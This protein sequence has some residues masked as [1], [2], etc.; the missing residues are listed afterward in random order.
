MRRLR[1]LSCLVP[2]VALVGLQAEPFRGEVVAVLPETQQVTVRAIDA[3]STADAETV[4]VGPGD[5][6][7]AHAGWKV[8]GDLV[9]MG[10]LRRLQTVWPDDSQAWAMVEQLGSRLIVDTRTRGSRAFRN[11]GEYMPAVALFD[12][13]GQLFLSESLKGNYVV[14]NFIFTR[15]PVPT[16]CPLSTQKMIDLQAAAQAAGIT[17]VELVS[18]TLDPDYDTP[19]IFTAYAQS[20]SI[21][22]THFHFLGGP[23]EILHALRDQMG[24]LAEPDPKQIVKH[25]LSTALI[26][27]TGKII[28]RV[29]GSQWS[30]ADFLA[31]IE[32]HRTA[33]R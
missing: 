30:A 23:K 18:C 1:F 2:L 8:R 27:P 7:L 14:M 10:A 3:A 19:G 13:D 5:L 25:T 22:T 4:F 12:Q 11:V 16:M 31:Q 9:Q 29:P 24:V 32:K 26:D 28:Y 20:R 33:Q 15:C 21:D 6:K 17:D